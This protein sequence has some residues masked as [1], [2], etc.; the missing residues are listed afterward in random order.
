MSGNVIARAALCALIVAAAPVAARVTEINVTAVE[1]FAGGA[2]F[3]DTGAYERVK[4]A[5]ESGVRPYY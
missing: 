1:P 5:L 2:G 4:G 3:G